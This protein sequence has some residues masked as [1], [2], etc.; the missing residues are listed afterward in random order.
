M[1]VL[2]E[3]E[4]NLCA[5][6][7]ILHDQCKCCLHSILT[8]AIPEVSVYTHIHMLKSS[9]V[10]SHCVLGN[11]WVRNQ[12]PSMVWLGRNDEHIPEWVLPQELLYKSV[13]HVTEPTLLPT[14]RIIVERTVHLEL[15]GDQLL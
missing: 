12:A 4:Y 8:L 9:A 10:P 15:T 11:V 2:V 3:S 6:V 1:E 13:I 5:I 14:N 7:L